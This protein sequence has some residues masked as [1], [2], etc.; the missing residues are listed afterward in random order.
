MLD[1]ERLYEQAIRSARASGFVHSE[2]I[3]NEVAGR[4]YLSRGLEINA[5][6]HLRNA[7]ACFAAWGAD[8]KVLQLESRY[9]RLVSPDARMAMPGPSIKQLDFATILKASQAV[10]SEI[11]FPRL[12][13][14][15]MT[16]TL[17]NA[18]AD[19]GLL[20]LPLRDEYRVETE[21]LVSGNNVVL[22]HGPAMNPGMP[23]TIVRYVMR[24]RET[25]ILE[26]AAKPNLFSED[27]YL[28]G[29]QPRSLLCLPLMRQGTLSGLLYLE[30]T[31]ASHAF[32]PARTALLELLAS[33]EA[34]SLENTRLYGDLKEREAK[35]RRL[36]DANI[37][38]IF[39]WELHGRIVD[40]N[41]AFL[42]LVG[43]SREDLVSGRMSWRGLTPAEWRGA[44]DRRVAELEATGTA[45]P[46][47]KEYLRKDGNRVPVL[48]GAASFKKGRDEGVGFVVDLTDRKRAE[49]AVRDSERRYLEVEVALAHAN[50]LATV[51]QLSASIAHEVKQP[52]GAAVT[53][54]QAA[55]RWLGAQPPQIEEA[56]RA[57]SRVVKNGNRAGEVIGRIR[58]L[59]RKADPRKDWLQINEAILEVIALT[60]GEVVKNGVSVRTQ[61]AAALPAVHADRVQLQQVILNL[62]VNSV[63]AMSGVGVGSREMLISTAKA[64]SNVLVAVRDSGPG[65]APESVDRI[66]E[67][68]YTTKP[69]GLGI[70][71]SICSSIIE[72]H[73]GRLWASANEPRG[74]AFEFTLPVHPDP[75]SPE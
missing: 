17:Q 38:G 18:G 23:E 43:Y 15:L 24:T 28:S 3:A 69:S 47:E 16:I 58:A 12:V 44:D 33:Q 52:I 51:G 29:G 62:M 61:L 68:F 1:A 72:A 67:A 13:E 22:R 57:I 19:R 56:R 9:P 2:G 45:Q 31:L 36:V 14:Q 37:I 8:A 66:F 64:E 41:E 46:Y 25:V 27:E 4:F 74:A 7:V 53:N 35:I 21:A 30:N 70:G 20:L 55:L 75:L 60:H 39:I 65:F 40:A 42:R 48:V 26:D 59:V 50:R 49:Q 54:A 6:A 71:L 73:G 10:S 34:I 5:Y 32:T 11:V 63:E